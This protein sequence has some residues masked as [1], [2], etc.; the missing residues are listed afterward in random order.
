MM[1]WVRRWRIKRMICK[2]QVPARTARLLEELWAAE[3]KYGG[4]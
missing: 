1:R 3:K 4:P 2:G